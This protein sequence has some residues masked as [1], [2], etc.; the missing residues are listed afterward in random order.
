LAESAAQADFFRG[1]LSGGVAF[2][3][4][5]QAH[6]EDLTRAKL[7]T[8]AASLALILFN[9]YF[10]GSAGSGLGVERFPPQFGHFSNPGV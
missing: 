6:D 7:D 4:Y 5:F 1:D 9:K 8:V 2:G 3:V 10:A